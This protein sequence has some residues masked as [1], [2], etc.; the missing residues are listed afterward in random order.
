MSL[1]AEN[2]ISKNVATGLLDERLADIAA[3]I[4]AARS[5]HCVVLREDGVSFFGLVRFSDIAARA[6]PGLRIL[7][8][9]IAPVSP[10][11]IRSHENAERVA[12][13]F[14]QHS[15]GEAVVLGDN[16]HYVGLITAESVLAWTRNELRRSAC[17]PEVETA[18][19]DTTVYKSEPDNRGA[20]SRSTLGSILLVE[21]HE[22]S[23]NALAQ[24]LRRRNY[25]VIESSS[26]ADALSRAATIDFT[27]VISDIGLPDG[28]GYQ[29]ISLLREKYGVRGIAIS[30]LGMQSDLAR[31]ISAGFSYHLKKPVN[32]RDLEAAI[33]SALVD[34][35][36]VE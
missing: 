12:D 33:A 24:I 3:R 13:L 17:N 21:D 23:R 27:L 1:S 5:H 6:N 35:A 32:V 19:S 16:D 11:I 4:T 22:P 36:S 18:A 20:N 2:L 9:L 15:V 31:S 25:D 7:G 30:G 34:R 10:L 28:T 14:E 26:M 29:L 8:D